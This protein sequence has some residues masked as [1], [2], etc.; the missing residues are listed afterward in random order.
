MTERGLTDKSSEICQKFV[1]IPQR[2]ESTRIRID[3]GIRLEA[4]CWLNGYLYFT[5]T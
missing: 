2:I 4:A 5:L 3:A 1:L